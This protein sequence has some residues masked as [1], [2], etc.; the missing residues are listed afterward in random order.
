VARPT[1]G[2]RP[3]RSGVPRRGK[4]ARRPRGLR[5]RAG[6]RRAPRRG[7]GTID[8]GGTVIGRLGSTRRGRGTAPSRPYP[9]R[10]DTAGHPPPGRTGGAALGRCRTA[11]RHRVGDGTRRGVRTPRHGA[12]DRHGG[13][14]RT[15]FRLEPRTFADPDHTGLPGR[16]GPHPVG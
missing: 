8:T 12:A 10:A 13:L 2:T 3:S 5:Q 11:D 4:T 1:T 14:P 6:G 7:R 15:V 16:T 9:L